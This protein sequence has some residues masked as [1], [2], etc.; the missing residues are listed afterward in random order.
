MVKLTKIYTRTGDKGETALVNGTRVPKHHLR[1]SAYGS[2]DEV[3]AAV[4]LARIGLDGELD[5]QLS[6]IQNDLFDLGADLATPDQEGLE[7]EPLRIVDSQVE[8]L[9]QTID[10]MNSELEKLRSFILPAG[11][12]TAA[13]LHHARTVARRAERDITALST[14][15]AVNPAAVSY[16]NRLSDLLF[17][18]ARF[19]NR[20]EGSG[21]VLWEPGGSR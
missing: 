2:V 11:T 6:R 21:D 3:N 9:E 14:A 13:H 15:E 16:M 18:A 4:G 20:R 17:V 10:V 12:A 19:V 7:F 8:W 5:A 1:V